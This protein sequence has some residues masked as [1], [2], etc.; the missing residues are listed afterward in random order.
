MTPA[1]DRPYP[2]NPAGPFP[3]PP[4]AFEDAEDR[5]I[6][7]RTDGDALEEQVAMYRAFRPEDRAQGIPPF[8]EPAIRDWLGTLSEGV[9]VLAWHE[10]EVVGHATLVSD[11]EGGWELAIFVLRPYQGAG[12][13]TAL[14]EHLLGEARE[15][16]IE[17]VWLTVERWNRAAIRLYEG[18]GF[19]RTESGRVELEMSLRL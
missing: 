17:K 3:R 7:V 8:R 18:V 11:G 4:H 2:D 19:E 6:E 13:G 10:D 9:N 5:R 16:G 14:V 12:I 15:Q 1:S